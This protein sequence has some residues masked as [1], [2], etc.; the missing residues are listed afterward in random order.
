MKNKIL[1][2]LCWTTI[3]FFFLLSTII[4]SL[5]TWFNMRFTVTFEEILFTLTSPLKGSD[6]SFLKEALDFMMPT[7][8]NHLILICILASFV[9]VLRIVIVQLHIT[10]GKLNIKLELYKLY[11][12]I[13]IVATFA[14]CFNSINFAFDSLNLKNYI[15][16]KCDKT[17]IYEDYYVDPN[18]V[19][20]T[21]SENTKNLIYIYLESLETT[22][23][24]TNEGGYQEINYIPNLTQL[25]KE[26]ISFSHN[27]LLG[28]A[29]VTPGSG[30]TMGALLSTTAGVPFAFPVGANSMDTFE[31]FAPGLTSL[32]DILN[33]FDYTQVFLCGS[34]G[35][36]AGR[37]TY[38]EQHGNYDV[39][40]YYD[41]IEKGYINKD[42]F[43][44]WGIED[45]KLY[46]VAKDELLKL[47]EQDAP[48][49][50]TML[51]VDT[52]HTDGYIC[53]IC[54]N[55]YP[56]QLA[57]VISC[58]D[59]QIY[60]FI[61]WCKKQTFYENTTIIITGDHFRM[62]SSLIGETSDRKVYNCYVNS[63]K[64]PMNNLKNRSFTSLDFFPT[65][66]SAMGFQI[67]GDRLGL[68]TDLF[69]STATL[70]EE[71]E[72]KKL[73]EELGKHS[74]YYVK[75]FQ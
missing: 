15:S 4:E 59:N 27:N 61:D 50:F 52:H 43:V 11:Q 64:S 25:A 66:L 47:S 34:D 42:Y 2:I 70:A 46:E 1:T 6:V 23:A 51:T 65:T 12:I 30:W 40:D 53:D 67:E 3:G 14:C 28:G 62:D 7:F 36:F 10:V 26:N 37:Q 58:A 48:F 19:T 55:T 13:C 9:I 39:I 56:S 49:N 16:K 57:N 31:N 60:D 24:S 75:H 72:F 54:T 71:L 5:T 20:I 68:G 22:Y 8:I 44:W 17:T 74:N 33:Q 32:G 45:Q 21:K 18:S 73:E 41:I 35:T 69:S 29:N 63:A 38:F